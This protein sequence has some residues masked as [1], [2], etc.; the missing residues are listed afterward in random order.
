MNV[1]MY[2]NVYQNACKIEKY[3]FTHDISMQSANIWYLLEKSVK[4]NV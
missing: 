3:S 2:T 1:C 4:G